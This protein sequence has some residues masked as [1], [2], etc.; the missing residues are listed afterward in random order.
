MRLLK[1][2]AHCLT[3]GSQHAAQRPQGITCEAVYKG[4][5]HPAALQASGEGAG[6]ADLRREAQ[7]GL[8]RQV[9]PAGYSWACPAGSWYTEFGL[10][11]ATCCCT[12]VRA[13]FALCWA[14]TTALSLAP[15]PFVMPRLV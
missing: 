1:V 6:C 11:L 8:G 12:L 5:Q 9:L 4:T 2:K 7:A 15:V 3:Y 10:L 14:Q 13:C